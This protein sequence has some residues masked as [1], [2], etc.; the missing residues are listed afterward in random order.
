[1]SRK[2]WVRWVV[3]AVL[4]LAAGVA[5]GVFLIGRHPLAVYAWSTRRALFKA[6]FVEQVSAGPGGRL[7]Y[8]EEAPVRGGPEG[9]TAS[10]GAPTLVL[11]H[12]AGDQAGN[13]SQVAPALADDYRVLIPDLAGHGDSGPREGPLPFDLIVEGFELV[14]S[15]A[16]EDY[17]GPAILIGNSMGAWVASIY[18]E[19]HPDRVARLVLVNGGPIQEESDLTLLP[20]DREAARELMQALRDPGSQPIPDILLDDIVRRAH[21]GPIGRMAQVPESMEKYLLDGRLDQIKVP[22]DLL[23]GARDQLLPREYAERLAAGLPRARITWIE[24]CGHVP[25]AEC[26]ERFRE[27]LLK[28][29]SEPPPEAEATAEDETGAAAGTPD[30]AS[31]EVDQGAGP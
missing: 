21:A 30:G 1:M 26:P 9:A 22:V 4:A 7:A 12:G 16:V 6:G 8:F 13:W 29:L 24:A 5:V 23:W 27:A 14:M 19:R 28:V 17:R 15:R 31:Q 2:R 11:L 20:A 10:E 18:A 3:I 25:Q